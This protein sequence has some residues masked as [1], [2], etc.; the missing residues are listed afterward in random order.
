MTYLPHELWTVSSCTLHIY[1]IDI[2]IYP[3]ALPLIQYPKEIWKYLGFI[4]N[5][6]SPTIQT[7]RSW[8]SKVWKYL[9]IQ[10]EDY[11]LFKNNS[12]IECTSCLLYYIGFLYNSITKFYYYSLSRNSEK[13]KEVQL[14]KFLVHSTYFPPKKLKY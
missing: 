13:C 4:F 10:Q 12:C 5:N 14:P 6:I 2:I 9:E 11:F 3:Y 1:S 8:P 7:K